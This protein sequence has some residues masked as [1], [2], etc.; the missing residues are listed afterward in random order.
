MTYVFYDISLVSEIGVG[1]LLIDGKCWVA[2]HYRSIAIAT[3]VVRS[4]KLEHENTVCERI[5]VEVSQR[6]LYRDEK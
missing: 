6:G 3:C 5:L 2:R 4:L 1:M